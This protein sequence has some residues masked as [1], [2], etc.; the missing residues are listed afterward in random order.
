MFCRRKPSFRSSQILLMEIATAM[1]IMTGLFTS[2]FLGGITTGVVALDVLLFVVICTVLTLLCMTTIHAVTARL[3][4]EHLFRFYWTF[5]AGL[6]MASLILVW[7]G[8]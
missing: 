5:V 7:V 8:L 3:K 6:A 1:I 4:I 2:L